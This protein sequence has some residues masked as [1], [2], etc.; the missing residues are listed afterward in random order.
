MAKIPTW[1]MGNAD[2]AKTR[3]NEEGQVEIDPMDQLAEVASDFETLKK[4]KQKQEKTAATPMCVHGQKMRMSHLFDH[5][6]T[7]FLFLRT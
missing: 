3:K 5:D 1:K 2:A 7:L 4:K 6:A